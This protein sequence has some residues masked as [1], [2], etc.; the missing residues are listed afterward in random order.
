MAD[1]LALTLNIQT[2]IDGENNAFSSD[3]DAPLPKLPTAQALDLLF[4]IVAHLHKAYDAGMA[5]NIHE[6]G[7]LPQA[8]RVRI[9]E[10][11]HNTGF[12]VTQKALA[13]LGSSDVNYI[14]ANAKSSIA[15]DSLPTVKQEM[16][17]K[18]EAIHTYLCEV[19]Q[20]LMGVVLASPDEKSNTLVIHDMLN[21]LAAYIAQTYSL[22][23]NHYPA[24]I[25]GKWWIPSCPTLFERLYNTGSAGTYWQQGNSSNLQVSKI[26]IEQFAQGDF[27]AGLKLFTTLGH[28]MLH[29]HQSEQMYRGEGEYKLYAM[30]MKAGESCG[31]QNE[32]EMTGL[33]Y[34]DPNKCQYFYLASE[35]EKEAHITQRY[36]A[37]AIIGAFNNTPSAELQ[38]YPNYP[39]NIMGR[40]VKSAAAEAGR[41]PYQR[42]EIRYTVNGCDRKEEL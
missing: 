30:L 11:L 21:G 41:Y 14:P 22:D 7:I 37:D 34:S 9:L 28:E 3:Y 23:L 24:M 32:K 26:L 20:P 4:N 17:R 42:Y 1:T 12:P 2:Q 35:H 13:I 18:A 39:K 29:R 38:A 33:S 16:E 19:T 27:A 36:W 25:D 40:R 31:R 15:P 6:S 5:Q 8:V 10:L